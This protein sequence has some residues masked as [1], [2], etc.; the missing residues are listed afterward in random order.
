MMKHLMEEGMDSSEA[1]VEAVALL[2][3]KKGLAFNMGDAGDTNQNSEGVAVN[4]GYITIST[5][6]GN[7]QAARGKVALVEQRLVGLD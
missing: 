2:K 1:Q 6:D 7:V 5:I 3:D 4:Q